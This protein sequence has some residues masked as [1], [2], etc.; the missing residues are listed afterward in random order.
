MNVQEFVAEVIISVA[1][2]VRNAQES[3]K[4]LGLT[5]NP[6]ARVFFDP[7]S[8][9]LGKGAWPVGCKIRF[10]IAVTT[11]ADKT[12]GGKAGLTVFGLGLGGEVASGQSNTHVSR[13]CFDVPVILPKGVN[14]SGT[15]E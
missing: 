11:V 13:V 4:E 3:G 2:G 5:V 1:E 12:Q 8:K 14:W 9:Q 10:D 7:D 6:A 15:S